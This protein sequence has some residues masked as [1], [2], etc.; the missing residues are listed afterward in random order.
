MTLTINLSFASKRFVPT[1]S[2]PDNKRRSQKQNYT[3]SYKADRCFY[4]LL[5]VKPVR[6]PEKAVQKNRKPTLEKQIGAE[7]AKFP[8]YS[9]SKNIVTYDNCLVNNKRKTCKSHV[10]FCENNLQTAHN[11][12]FAGR[13]K[14]NFLS[15][16]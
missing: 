1:S 10:V 7:K 5:W 8:Q 16:I 2:T 9:L 14:A 4:C 3:Q 13:T 15:D 6:R 12:S 11:E